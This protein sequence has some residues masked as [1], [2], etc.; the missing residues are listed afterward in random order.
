M[1]GVIGGSGFYQLPN[2][3]D[4]QACQPESVYGE[5]SDALLT[6]KLL[7]ETAL[8]Q[9]IC[10]LA[11]H[12]RNHELPPHA[13]NYRANIDV[14]A[15]SG[16][17]AI[18]AVNAVGGCLQNQ[19]PGDLLLPEQLIDYSWG[20]AHSFRE[21]LATFHQ[22]IDFTE[23]F[24]AGLR[25]AILEAA[26]HCDLPLDDGGTYACT[27]GPRFETA[28]EIRRLQRDGCTMVGMTAMPEAAL[29]RE[30]DIPY[31]SVCIVTNLAAGVGSNTISFDAIQSALD[32]SIISI[33]RMLP[34]LLDTCV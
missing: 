14:M 20:R 29:A 24:D 6:G 21:K 5:A 18:L 10:F 4:A 31:A 8:A 23:P 22:H 1:L 13:I 3:L 28:A 32:G 17:S 11:R 34:Y 7:N 16:V 26:S 12:G 15:Q 25:A 19:A 9:P 27:Q 30:L 2:L 33:Q